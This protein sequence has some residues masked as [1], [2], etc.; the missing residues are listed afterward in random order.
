M[1]VILAIVGS[2]GVFPSIGE[3]D[4]EVE[5]LPL[6]WNGDG[7]GPEAFKRVISAVIDGGAD[8]GDY[9]GRLWAQDRGIPVIDEPITAEDIRRSNKYV[10]PKHRNARVADRATLGLAF[11]DGLSSGTP[12]F[13]TRMQLRE[14]FV[15]V[16]PSKRVPGRPK[17]PRHRG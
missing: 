5:R 4:L 14:K 13:V 8:G 9:A 7:P 1:S 11:W 12:D 3:I 10:A 6:P 15:R 17:R 2:R 16:V